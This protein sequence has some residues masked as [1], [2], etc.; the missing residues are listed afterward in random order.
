MPSRPKVVLRFEQ[1]SVGSASWVSIANCC[2]WISRFPAADLP[3]W[4]LSYIGRMCSNSSFG[5]GWPTSSGSFTALRADPRTL[6]NLGGQFACQMLLKDT[7]RFGHKPT[8]QWTDTEGRGVI[9]IIYMHFVC[10]CDILWTSEQLYYVLKYM[11]YICTSLY[12][13]VYIMYIR[14]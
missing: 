13:F 2:S 1:G 3:V 9:C 14:T 11:V 7:N 6:L 8:R 12:V 4:W 5:E 10:F